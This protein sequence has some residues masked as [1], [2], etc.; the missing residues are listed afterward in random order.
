MVEKR[1][2]L[3]WWWQA[4]ASD[5]RLP[6]LLPISAFCAV[7][8]TLVASQ[9]DYRGRLCSFPG[10]STTSSPGFLSNQN[11][12]RCKFTG[13]L[14]S[15]FGSGSKTFSQRTTRWNGEWTVAA[16]AAAAPPRDGLC[17]YD[18]RVPANVNTFSVLFFFFFFFPAELL[19]A[20]WQW[21]YCWIQ[22]GA[23]SCR[24]PAGCY[25][26]VCERFV[27]KQCR[28]E[29]EETVTREPLTQWLLG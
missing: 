17:V 10:N 13:K 9:P 21:L 22:L 6:P 18:H 29:Q 27:W 20:A 5:Y 25:L 23:C 4:A 8:A 14:R 26:C 3:L 19:W 28:R 2:W 16:A 15:P 24:A 11:H 12:M 1:T 7:W